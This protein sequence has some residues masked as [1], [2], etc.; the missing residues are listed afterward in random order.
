MLQNLSAIGQLF[1][2]NL[3]NLQNQLARTQQQISSGVRISKPSDD[4][5]SVG[6]VLQLQSDL[7]KVTQVLS[8]L[9]Q[10]K[11][12]VD[13]GESSLETATQF[14]DQVTTLGTQGANSVTTAAERGD[15]A[16]QVT[17]LLTQLVGISRTQY[18]GAYIFSGDA[19]SSPA[20]Q[21]DLNSATG[22]DRLSTAPTTRLIQDATGVTFGASRTAQDIFDHRNADD[23]VASDNVF[24]A[25]NSLRVALTN[26]DQT[27]ITNALNSIK[28][29]G[30]YLSQQLAYYGGLQNQVANATTVAQ[31][32]QLQD[33]AS[34]SAK[35]DTNIAQAAVSL[36]QEQAEIQG[37]LQA[38]AAT[39]K[40]S[41]F[42][43]LNL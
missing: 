5:G 41:L 36:T 31:N 26:N 38:Q 18:A 37:S 12:E 9:S 28:Q 19:I 14:L 1:L 39:P 17:N 33:Q 40:S 27:G 34:L 29:A 32:F 30:G 16:N 21:L 7:G 23:S 2:A 24:A 6:D 3:G 20:Y 35:R 42:D 8:N 11:G 4:P 22:V 13:T 15:L 25:V 43:F 10:V